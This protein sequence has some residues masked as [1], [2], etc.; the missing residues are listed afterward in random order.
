[1]SKSSNETVLGISEAV[2]L[3]H[4]MVQRIADKLGIR[5]L[6]IK[7]PASVL[8]GLRESKTSTDVDVLVAPLGL[9]L[10]LQSLRDRGWR[11]RLVASDNRA[12]PMS[13]TVEK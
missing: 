1:M 9:E 2:C 4:A 8:Q 10:M 13:V 11:E 7:G 12:F 3:G 6:F 5:V